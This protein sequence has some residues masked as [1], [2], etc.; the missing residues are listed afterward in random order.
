MIPDP[1]LKKLLGRVFDDARE[2]LRDTMDRKTYEDLR[3][4]FVFH[5]TDWLQDLAELNEI[6]EHP[7]KI[8][9]NDAT[10]RIIGFLY[11]VI[12]HLK[13]AG[14]LLLDE[15]SDPFEDIQVPASPQSAGGSKKASR[16]RKPR[17]KAG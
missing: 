1:K 3:W 10:L 16:R 7:T 17:A 11:H 9:V 6:Y 12:S 4:E 14:R 2:G 13:T 5:M 15:I 8:K